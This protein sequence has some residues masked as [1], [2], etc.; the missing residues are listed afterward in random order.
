M[1]DDAPNPEVEAVRQEIELL[2][3]DMEQQRTEL[4][5]RINVQQESIDT[6]KALVYGVLIAVGVIV[7]GAR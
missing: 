1:S 4:E 6:L 5:G 3:K 7:V 2:R